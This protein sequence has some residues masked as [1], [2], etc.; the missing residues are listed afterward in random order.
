MSSASTQQPDTGDAHDN[1]VHVIAIVG[2]SAAGVSAAFTLRRE[3][4]TGR[5]V[6]IDADPELPYERPPL[7]KALN[8]SSDELC[9]PIAPA[10]DYH[11]NDIELRL[12]TRVVSLDPH[13][14]TLGFDDGGA[15]EADAVLL[16]AGA[17]PREAA[18]PGAAL[19]HITTLRTL[20]DARRLQARL[21]RRDPIVVIGGGFIGLEAA[22]AV[23]SLGHAVTVVEA[24]P[25]PL[26]AVLGPD[27]GR[28]ITGLHAQ[29]GVEILT[30]RTVTR[31]SGT[32]S[33]SSVELSSGESLPAGAVIVG[34]G[35]IAND[36]L[37]RAAGIDTAGGVVVDRYGRTSSPWVFAAGD[38]ACQPHPAL[39]TPG[40]IEHWDNAI[41]QGA[42]TARTI[43]ARPEEYAD[44]PYFWSDQ[45]R[46]KIQM[47]GR[48]AATD[49]VVVREGPSASTFTAAW[50]RDSQVVAGLGLNSPKDLRVL[51][52]LIE[53][54]APVT[55]DQ[56]SDPQVDLRQLASKAAV[57][58]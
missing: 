11:D 7:S 55:A 53:R 33:V 23:R 14:R 15:L 45:Y 17:R 37:A 20:D 32:G 18:V 13:T 41:K 39:V 36:E 24:G 47:Y 10:A 52:S 1:A 51:R 6:L 58:R 57:A 25:L 48:P 3:G 9:R 2:A 27:L 38:V 28:R 46:H 16:T 8:G 44:L 50:I 56:L 12:G 21:D 43:L 40:R 54:R 34:I 29:E 30:D 4:F 31:F 49:E 19:Q 22:A 35:V 5:V 42:A 26:A